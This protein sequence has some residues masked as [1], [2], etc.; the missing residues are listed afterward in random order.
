MHTHVGTMFEI[1]ERLTE[2]G[3]EISDEQ[4]ATYI[5]T[6]LTPT[7]CSLLTAMSAAARTMGKPVALDALVSAIIEEAETLYAEKKL[8]EQS[9]DSAMMASKGKGNTASQRMRKRGLNAKIASSLDTPRRNALPRVVE[10][11]T[12]HRIGG[13]K[14]LGRT[15]T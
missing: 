5:R 14:S 8:D 9:K 1:R 11:K 10:E 15:R 2:M 4:F 6:S 3:Y 12:R 13:K 7:F